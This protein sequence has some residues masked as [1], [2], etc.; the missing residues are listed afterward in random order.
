MDFLSFCLL[1]RLSVS[2]WPFSKVI[3]AFLLEMHG[4]WNCSLSVS[5]ITVVSAVVAS[6]CR[7]NDSTMHQCTSQIWL[8]TNAG[9]RTGYPVAANRLSRHLGLSNDS[10]GSQTRLFA[11]SSR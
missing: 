10:V 11:T 5:D 6:V 7:M 9:L 1:P 8:V 2:T 4:F 3:D